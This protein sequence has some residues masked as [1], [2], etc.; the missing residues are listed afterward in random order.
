MQVKTR[1]GAARRPFALLAVPALALAACSSAPVPPTSAKDVPELRKGSGY[2]IGYL[3]RKE[4][5][6]SLKLLPAPPAAG[7]AGLAADQAAFTATQAMRGSPRWQ[8]AASDANLRFPKAAGT[9]ACALDLPISESETP[10][11]NMLL[12]RTL[13]DA[14][15]ATYAAKDHYK[16][17][18]P[19]VENKVST[20]APGEEKRLINDGSY[21][22]G[23]SAL[24]WAWALVLA[25]L[26]PERADALF[27]RGHAFGQ[28]RVVCGVHW[29]S[30]VDAGRVV[31]AAAVARLHSDPVFLA[32]MAEARKEVTEA[33]A[34]GR[35][36]AGDCAAEAAAL[37]AR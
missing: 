19:F 26:A 13:I 7:S 4:L 17:K 35:R 23:H 3:P 36:A 34:K 8:L 9:F 25:E 12:R 27:A 1:R 21:P 18:R 16:R 31:G 15:L 10:H 6:D 20:C 33:R 2:L 32:Q 14:G 11:V 30:D 22:S 37:A 24:G 28:S 5:P 29:Q